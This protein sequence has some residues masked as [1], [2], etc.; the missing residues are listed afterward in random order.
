MKTFKGGL[1]VIPAYNENERIGSII[2]KINDSVS[3]IDIL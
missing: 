3:D 1:V 2:D